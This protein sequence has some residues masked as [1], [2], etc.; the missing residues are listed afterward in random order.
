MAEIIDFE[1]KKKE[2]DIEVKLEKD[3]QDILET[4]IVALWSLIKGPSL[5]DIVSEEQYLYFFLQFSGVCF[6]AMEEE[7]IRVDD[8]GNMAIIAGLRESMEDA[9]KDIERELATKH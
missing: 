1:A 2:R 4:A 7:A 5:R 3:G 9:V 8:A 6:E